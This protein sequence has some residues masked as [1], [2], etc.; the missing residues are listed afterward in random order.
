MMQK[1]LDIPLNS[2]WDAD[3]SGIFRIRYTDLAENKQTILASQIIHYGTI[4]TLKGN[5]GPTIEETKEILA[6]I[7]PKIKKCHKMIIHIQ[8][9][10]LCV[11]LEY[12]EKIMGFISARISFV[13]FV[14][15]DSAGG[16]GIS[17]WEYS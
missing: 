7:N 5:R 10:S 12:W 2:I 4:R 11:S 13:S 8:L 3:P 17:L 15:S 14:F 9:R 1:K 6:E 16:I